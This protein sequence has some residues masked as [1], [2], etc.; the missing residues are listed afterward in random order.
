MN[1]EVIKYDLFEDED[2]EYTYM[3]LEA[4]KILG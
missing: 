3:R 4:I 1:W 2:V